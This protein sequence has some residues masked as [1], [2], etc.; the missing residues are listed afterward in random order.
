VL[1]AID[2]GNTNLA[3]G[4][5]RDG[6]LSATCGWRP[7]PSA[8]PTSTV[9]TVFSCAATT[10]SI[11]RR[12]GGGPRLGGP[13]LEEAIVRCAASI[14]GGSR[15]LPGGYPAGAA[16]RVSSAGRSGGG[17]GGERGGGFSQVRRPA[18][19]RGF[20]HRHHPG[21]GPCR[22]GIRRRSD[23]SGNP[24]RHGGPGSAHGPVAESGLRPS[25]PAD[26]PVDGG[27][28]PIG[29]YYGSLF[30]V[31]GLVRL[32]RE[33]LGPGTRVVAT[34]GLA[35]AYGDDLPWVDAREP[36]LT[37]EGL[38]YIYRGHADG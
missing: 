12:G 26:R 32:F 6:A 34:G 8:P 24:A 10:A 36:H 13:P 17:S 1:L 4:V 11:R 38:Y 20:R 22:W 14:S 23:P 9:S 2:I 21:R 5:F 15:S 16:D 30:M 33:E 19:D 25:A 18:G 37:L 29:L 31:E 3:C 35:G 7:G 28:P 27:G